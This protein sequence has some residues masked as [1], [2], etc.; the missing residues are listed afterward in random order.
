[1]TIK[2]F[3]DKY[4]VPYNMAYEASY[5]VSPVGTMQRDKDFPEDD[6]F[7]A[8]DKL[9]EKRMQYHTKLMRS[10]QL[11]YVNMHN[12]KRRDVCDL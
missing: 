7:V 2:E 12:K 8:T 4:D 1:M 6:L 5:R 11:A 9:L 3:S 10:A